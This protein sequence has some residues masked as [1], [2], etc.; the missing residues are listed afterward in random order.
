MSIKSRLAELCAEACRNCAKQQD[1]HEG[2]A[3][4]IHSIANSILDDLDSIKKLR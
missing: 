1:C 3:C 2:D 4:K